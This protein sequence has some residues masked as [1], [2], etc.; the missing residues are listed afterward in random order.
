MAS[1][2]A[3][4]LDAMEDLLRTVVDDKTLNCVLVETIHLI[5]LFAKI[6]IG[7]PTNNA[8]PARP[9]MK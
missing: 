1:G 4:P 6:A 9:L 5:D 2:G 3:L 7:R 8:C